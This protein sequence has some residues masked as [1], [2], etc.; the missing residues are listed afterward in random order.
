MHELGIAQSILDITREHLPPE[1]HGAVEVVR[2]RVGRMAGVVV[3]SLVFCFEAL[4]AG[5]PLEG[6]RLE[7]EE[8]PVRL[9]CRGCGKELVTPTLVLTCPACGSPETTLLSGTELQ[10]VEIELAEESQD[11]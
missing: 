11:T 3:E 4:V 2:V 10:M 6:A 5:T 9:R 8:V 7:V 1:G